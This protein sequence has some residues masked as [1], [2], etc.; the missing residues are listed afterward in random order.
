MIGKALGALA[1]VVVCSRVHAQQLPP[2]HPLGPVIHTA[3]E[4]L[5]AVS[6]ARQLPGGRVLVND[7]VGRKVVMYDSALAQL[8]IVA[9]TTSA[10]ANAYSSRTGGL[11]AYK[12]DSSLFV[13]PQSLSML[14]L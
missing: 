10:T 3:A 14:V 12:G 13:D 5:G 1:L 7:I 9:D 6:T 11:L 8:K 2:I 4:P